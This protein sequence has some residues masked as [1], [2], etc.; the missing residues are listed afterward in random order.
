M[1][2]PLSYLIFNLPLKYLLINNTLVAQVSNNK[3]LLLIFVLE[4][5]FTSQ[6]NEIMFSS[7]PVK[8]RNTYLL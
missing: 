6:E 4:R 1:K 7:Y 3:D 8:V 2:W 5:K